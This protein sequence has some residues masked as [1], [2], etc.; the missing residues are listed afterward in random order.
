MSD[1]DKAAGAGAQAG[2]AKGG[3]GAAA[4]GEEVVLYE[5]ADGIATI[6]INRPRQRNAL[7]VAT[8]NRLHD[9]WQRVDEDHAVRAVILTSAD[10]GTFCAG[11]DLREAAQLRAERGVD[12]LKLL[13]DPFQARMR[14]VRKPIVAAMTGHLMAGGMLL[15]L[16]ADLRVGL[17]GTTAGITEARVGRGSPW[18]VPLLWMIPQPLLMELVLT[19]EPQP[20][21]RFA[22]LGF[23]NYL[24]ATPAAVRERA[25][26][27]ARRIGENA[28]L[29]VR[30]GKA[31]ILAAMSAGCDAGLAAAARLHR[32]AYESEDAQEGPRAF[33]EKRKP[34][35]KG[36]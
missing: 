20:I 22:Q 12:V 27:L 23:V 1:T 4:E 35:W 21:E 9:L 6:T 34:V 7:S 16:N 36:R 28:P 2:P 11:M 30:A 32:E 17:A 31:S 14:E 15:A 25:T 19:A 24:E 8:S 13:K 3:A 26:A 29:S 33:A 10:C 18:A 5:V